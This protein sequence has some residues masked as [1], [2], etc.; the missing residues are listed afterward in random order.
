[1]TKF[2]KIVEIM[3][4]GDPTGNSN[5]A[6]YPEYYGIKQDIVRECNPK[7]ICEIGVRAGYSAVAFMDACPDAFYFGFDA[8]N[9]THGG[10]VG[11]TDWAKKLLAGRPAKIWCPFDSQKA[12]VLP[13]RAD[14]Y[15]IDGDHTTAGCYHDMLICFEDMLSGSFMLVDDFDFLGDVRRGMEMFIKNFSQVI[16][17]RYVKSK[18]G[19]ML[20]RKL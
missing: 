19:E 10:H 5:L 4:P 20:I 9:G 15:H 8:D 14:F 16:L 1:M 6:W 13:V 2:D 12:K 7:L 18:R 17:P 11:F 3:H